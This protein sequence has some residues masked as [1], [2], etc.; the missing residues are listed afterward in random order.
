[1]GIARTVKYHFDCDTPGCTS[2]VTFGGDSFVECRA[3]E[4][5]PAPDMFEMIETLTAE[6]WSFGYSRVHCP[7]HTRVVTNAALLG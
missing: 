1:V 2:R 6:G 3:G 4:F 5:D 7:S